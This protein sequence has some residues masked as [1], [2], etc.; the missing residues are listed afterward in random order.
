MARVQ[1]VEAGSFGNAARDLLVR[2]RAT[3]GGSPEGPY[4]L[5]IALGELTLSIGN[6]EFFDQVEGVLA[7]LA[8]S[9]D[10]ELFVLTRYDRAFL[11]RTDYW[12]T[13]IV[14]DVKIRLVQL[15]ERIVPDYY[16]VIDQ[17]RLF[18][19]FDLR[20]K[21]EAA[22]SIIES[23]AALAGSQGERRPPPKRKLLTTQHIRELETV[24][25]RGG[26]AAFCR[27]FVTGQD[28]VLVPGDRA[29]EPV[30]TEFFVST[31]NLRNRLFPGVDLTADTAVF[32][33]LTLSLDRMIMRAIPNFVGTA[34]QSS[35][36]L[37]VETAKSEE[38]AAFLAET[39][40]QSGASRLAF[41]FRVTD[42]LDNIQVFPSLAKR[43]AEMGA[44]VIADFVHPEMLGVVQFEKLPVQMVKILWEPG[45]GEL[46]AERRNEIL[47]L[48]RDQI[49]IALCRVD[50]PKAIP[51]GQRLGIVLF[52]G[53]AISGI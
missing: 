19:V 26:A 12:V 45:C 3:A 52:Q 24:F 18:R 16:K 49:A 34:R 50:D 9:N 5:V 11:A 7:A 33:L 38:F 40:S 48:S 28:I 35:I 14:S 17:A 41:E 1:T 13:R 36:N 42:I 29:P 53:Y 20:R 22:I 25:E 15:I 8:K 31:E 32:K 37:N 44:K 21:S 46:L 4:L 39:C 51:L 23:Y 2:L 10:C 27:R 47:A 43:I 30:M 6:S